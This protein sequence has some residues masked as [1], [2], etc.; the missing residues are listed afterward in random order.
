[1][2]SRAT[3]NIEVLA[4]A[5]ARL[6]TP[7]VPEAWVAAYWDASFCDVAG[8]S[9]WPLEEGLHNEGKE[10]KIITEELA[11]LRSDEEAQEFWL[12]LA[13]H[14][15]SHRALIA[16][17]FTLI[18]NGGSTADSA[19]LAATCYL[20][21]IQVPGSA[22]HKAYNSMI[23]RRIVTLLSRWPAPGNASTETAAKG[24]RKGR[25]PVAKG[26]ARKNRREEE[27][28]SDDEAGP[29]LSGAGAENEGS[30]GEEGGTNMS[31]ITRVRPS[32]GALHTT[33]TKLV[34]FLQRHSMR[35]QPDLVEHLALSLS[36][37]A[38]ATAM[39]TGPNSPP[40]L[41]LQ[42]LLGLCSGPPGSDGCVEAVL[43][44]LLATILMKFAGLSSTI[45]RPILRARETALAFACRI[46]REPAVAPHARTLFQHVCLGVVD[47]AEY[48]ALSAQ[49]AADLW[50]ALPASEEESLTTWLVRLARNARQGTRT[51]AVDTCLELL[52]RRPADTSIATTL[53]GVI[54]SRTSDKAPTVRAR[55]LACFASLADTLLPG[56]EAP[57][58]KATRS[59]HHME[60]AESKDG[61]ES[62]ATRAPSSAALYRGLVEHVAFQAAV[63]TPG[64]V[65]GPEDGA[66]ECNM[67][68]IARHRCADAKAGVRRAAVAA[69]T[70]IAR[71]SQYRFDRADLKHLC[72][73]GRDPVLSVRRQALLGLTDLLHVFADRPDMHAMWLDSVLPLALDREDTVRAKAIELMGT[74]LL[75]DTPLACA[76]VRTLDTR[77]DLLCY[78]QRACADWVSTKALTK[79]VMSRLVEWIAREDQ[80]WAFLSELA[81][82]VPALVAV[83]PIEA[84][85]QRVRAP[86]PPSASAS[87][88]SLSSSVAGPGG[89]AVSA[90]GPLILTILGMLALPP[91]D[92]QRLCDDLCSAVQTFSLPV[93]LIGV[94]LAVIKKLGGP[95]G[96]LIGVLTHLEEELG[97]CIIE[98]LPSAQMADEALARRLFTLGEAALACPGK[99]T[100]RSRLV[101]HAVI[102]DVTGDRA[103]VRAHAFL[104][105]GKLCLQDE[106]L[107]KASIALMARELQSGADAAARNNIVVILADLSVRYAALLEPHVATMAACVRDPSPLVRRQTL[108]L[109]TRLLCEDY[110]KLKGSLFFR[111]VAATADPDDSVATLG[112]YCLTEPL[113]SKDQTMFPTHFVETVFHLNG[114]TAHK[115]Y[116][117]F[118]QSERELAL[119]NM[120]GITQRRA[121]MHV[122]GLMLQRCS[123]QDKL[124]LTHALCQDVLAAIVDGTLPLADTADTAADTLAILA[125]K[126]MKLRSGRGAAAD[127]DD[128]EQAPL[129]K[130]T[131]ALI[132]KI[133]KKHLVQ[134]IMPII[135]ALKGV[136]EKAH[137]PLLRGLMTYLREVMRDYRDE[138]E[139]ILAADR[140]LATE[141]LF[142]LKQFEQRRRSGMG[143]PSATA[144]TPA[145]ARPLVSP[146][147]P[148]SI[149]RLKA[150]SRLADASPGAPRLAQAE[151]PR[152]SDMAWVRTPASKARLEHVADDAVIHLRTPLADPAPH[153]VWALASPSFEAELTSP[154]VARKAAPRA[155]GAAAAAGR[156]RRGRGVPDPVLEE[157]EDAVHDE[158]SDTNGTRAAGSKTR[159]KKSEPGPADP[160][161]AP[162]ATAAGAAASGEETEAEALSREGELTAVTGAAVTGAAVTGAAVVAGGNRPALTPFP[163]PILVEIFRSRARLKR[164]ESI[165]WRRVLNWL[166]S[167]GRKVM[168]RDT[169]GG[170]VS[171]RRR[172]A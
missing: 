9:P 68:Q 77:Q 14:K 145:S 6:G 114:C 149:P 26:R 49:A 110:I 132:S 150:R 61:E 19:A 158:N 65:G 124:Q 7:R 51:M 36:E 107:A 53:L 87:S 10:L 146:G 23:V 166:P 117:R 31:A 28:D 113:H 78:L 34:L 144:P 3:A 43:R 84:A 5:L 41:A 168:R 140:Q 8:E 123:D 120:Q 15:Y 2:S 94:A 141:I 33:L 60:E 119:F 52:L 67:L 80:G 12:M 18:E 4:A 64:S 100:E 163:G 83:G 57:V 102:A 40:E 35:G 91:R 138:A 162:A 130:A 38:R 71:M 127:S 89:S 170:V 153:P 63:A 101:L 13:D 58:A 159:A 73:R 45:P 129:A 165:V 90:A 95:Q 62:D 69:L 96:M 103:A 88:L 160:P 27:S 136:L 116:N 172:R 156:G 72:D 99:V 143:T 157:E 112:A 134:H 39:E 16:I 37:I 128:E 118:S 167:G 106:H 75:A 47:R 111:L 154:T 151:T 126:D 97:A 147:T 135:I 121:R 86:A 30:E 1:M 24:K 46:I 50:L 66:T 133:A 98:A 55:A 122:Y 76:L 105:L 29:P 142:D 21:L 115:T 139:D 131:A 169:C 59:H 171:L 11:K 92:A 56:P 42:G 125:S 54:T 85:W 109:L 104:A 70:A 32:A 48:R 44:Q 155:A 22:A 25:S 152:A 148:F 20:T 164:R 81:T 137:S 74:V 161:P 82:R 108:T 17:L 93:S 79:P